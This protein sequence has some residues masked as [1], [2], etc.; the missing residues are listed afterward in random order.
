MS[1]HYPVYEEMVEKAIRDKRKYAIQFSKDRRCENFE[2]KRKYRNIATRKRRKAI[3]ANWC[4]KSEELKSKPR[5]FYKIFKPF[6][7][8]KTKDSGLICLKTGGGKVEEEMWGDYFSTAAST[9]IQ[10]NFVDGTL[11]HHLNY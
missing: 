11:E 9:Q 8:N 10:G 1:D 3:K 4:N 7:S 2:L 6:I 5:E